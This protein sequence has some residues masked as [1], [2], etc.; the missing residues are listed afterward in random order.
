M[1]STAGRSAIWVAQV[2][3]LLAYLLCFMVDKF[4]I[5][6]V[7]LSLLGKFFCAGKLLA[8]AKGCSGF[9]LFQEP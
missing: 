3:C 7:F 9:L 4:I 5:V 2:S 8:V 6:M 1:I